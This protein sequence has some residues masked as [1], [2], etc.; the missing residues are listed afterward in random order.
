MR[1]KPALLLAP[2]LLVAAAALAVPAA[3]NGAEA[4]SCVRWRS[5]ARYK[6]FGYDHVV[7]LQN[8]CDAPAIC[9]VK[10]NVNPEPISAS[11]A[12]GEQTEVLTFR[13]SPASTFDARVSCALEAG[14]RR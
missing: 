4:L 10:T 5:E 14:A 7:I 11:V 12:P 3:D 1:V 2:A 13:G 6:N 8:G 9:S